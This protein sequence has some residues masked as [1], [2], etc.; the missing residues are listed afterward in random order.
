MLHPVAVRRM[1][2]QFRVAISFAGEQRD[3]VRGMAEE[4]ERQ[5]GEETVFLDEWYQ[6]ALGGYGK[7]NMLQDI[8]LS[9]CD[10][11]VLCVSTPYATKAWTTIEHEA[12]RARRM[13][14][15]QG[16]RNDDFVLPIRVGDGDVPGIP[17]NA[18]VPDFRGKLAKDAANLVVERLRIVCESMTS[19]DPGVLSKSVDTSADWPENAPGLHWPMA[20]HTEA[21]DAFRCLFSKTVRTRALLI[22]GQSGTG[23]THMAKQ[24]KLNGSAQR[25]VLCGRF[26]FKGMTNLDDEVDQFA[27]ELTLD[28]PSGIRLNE[29]LGNLFDQLRTRRSPTLLI[30][31][32]FEAGGE[33]CTWVERVALGEL[34][35]APW[36]RVV[37]I[38]Q[39]VP[40]RAGSTWA[41]MAPPTIQLEN[42]GPEHW[43][44]YG[45]ASR[46]NANITIAA[47]RENHELV[48]GHATT[49]A[50]L[51]GPKEVGDQ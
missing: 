42:P 20:D 3:F 38:G 14:A 49:L 6:A 25:D 28:K 31:D 37:V 12:I 23:K 45:K 17:F 33:A 13:A 10:L 26:D 19:S 40:T 34:D 9:K 29:R 51:Y 18:I 5:L 48:F 44:E 21:R 36:L 35:R 15:L 8:Y 39:A 32:T 7:D 4:V 11:V 24:M 16:G 2:E 1:P 30:F 43:F 47:V 27:R 41:S 50:G 22:L 46:P